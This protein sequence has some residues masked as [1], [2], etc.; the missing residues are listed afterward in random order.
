MWDDGDLHLL[1]STI[2]KKIKK[3]KKRKEKKIVVKEEEYNRA[4]GP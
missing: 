4:L 2:K 3:N 1:Q